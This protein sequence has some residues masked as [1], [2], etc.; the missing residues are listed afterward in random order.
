MVKVSE[1][2]GVVNAKTGQTKC[3]CL[4]VES[5]S[6]KRITLWC[7]NTLVYNIHPARGG[8]G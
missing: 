4:Y 2:T 1:K 5:K 3:C 6:A 7:D 8:I